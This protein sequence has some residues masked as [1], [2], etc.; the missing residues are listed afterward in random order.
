M[1]FLGGDN[2]SLIGADIHREYCPGIIEGNNIETKQRSPNTQNRWK[3]F[4]KNGLLSIEE[5]K[6]KILFDQYIKMIEQSKPLVK[7]TG[8]K[9]REIV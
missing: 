5:I 6:E 1:P 2:I 7:F 3:A 9:T 4:P 8:F